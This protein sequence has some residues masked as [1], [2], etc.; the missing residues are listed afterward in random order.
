MS[1]W[2][3]FPVWSPRDTAGNALIMASTKL[4]DIA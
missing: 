4:G 3:G 2:K 1:G